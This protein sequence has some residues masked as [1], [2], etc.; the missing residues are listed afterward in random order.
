MTRCS[1]KRITHRGSDVQ[2]DHICDSY[3][4]F[5]CGYCGTEI[6]ICRCCDHGHAYCPDEEC[7]ALAREPKV[8]VYRANY[9]G[10]HK[11]RKTHAERQMRYRMRQELALIVGTAVVTDHP[12]TFSSSSSTVLSIE[13]EEIQDDATPIE[14]SSTEAT[15]ECD[16]RPPA[17]RSHVE[18]MCCDVCG[19][20]CR[21]FIHRWSSA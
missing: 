10:T 2:P 18:L 19:R 6:R 20:L 8:P 3:R 21:P 12:S 13:D 1:A 11:G 5:E 17:I 7:A 4:E 14:P 9:E 16:R 15:P